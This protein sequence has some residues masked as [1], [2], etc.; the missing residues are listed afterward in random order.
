MSAFCLT[1]WWK[2]TS[3]CLNL[4]CQILH[5]LYMLSWSRHNTVLLRNAIVLCHLLWFS[6]FSIVLLQAQHKLIEINWLKLTL[7]CCYALWSRTSYEYNQAISWQV[8]AV[9]NCKAKIV[10]SWLTSKL[11]FFMLSNIVSN[12]TMKDCQFWYTFLIP[13]LSFHIKD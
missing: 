9:L 4:W 5:C 2:M 6:K 1:K 11:S 10:I 7:I 13:P 12:V 8:W 3:H